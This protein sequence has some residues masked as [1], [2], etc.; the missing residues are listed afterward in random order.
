[1]K[2]RPPPPPPPVRS[3]AGV[4][5]VQSRKSAI[6]APGPW[7]RLPSALYACRTDKSLLAERGGRFLIINTGSSAHQS[8]TVCV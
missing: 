2:H 3:S 4:L 7:R 8:P 1:M 5:P 6:F